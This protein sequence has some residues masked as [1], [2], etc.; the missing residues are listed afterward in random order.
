M[1]KTHHKI[2]RNQVPQENQG[3]SVQQWRITYFLRVLVLT[4]E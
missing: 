4:Q 2:G 1:F 3:Y